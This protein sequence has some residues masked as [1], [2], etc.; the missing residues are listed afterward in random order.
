MPAGQGRNNPLLPFDFSTGGGGSPPP[1]V[2]AANSAS[3]QS[4]R[5][6]IERLAA[7]EAAIEVA[8]AA[9]E[10]ERVRR[11]AADAPKAVAVPP[12]QRDLIRAMVLGNVLGPPPGLRRTRHHR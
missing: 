8:E 6:K 4:L 2:T 10:A 5:A 3:T 7:E 12:R 1:K 11:E 9:E